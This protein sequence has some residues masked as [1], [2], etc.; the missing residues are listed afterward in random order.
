MV[1]KYHLRIENK[2]VR[3]DLDIKR[4]FTVIRGNSAM[5]KTYL[6]D[7][8]LNKETIVTCKLRVTVLPTQKDDY[9]D[10][11]EKSN[12]LIIID[13]DVDDMDTKEFA[14]LLKDSNNYFIIFSRLKLA[15][16]P[17][18]LEEIY[19]FT[20][21]TKYNNMN[22]PFTLTTLKSMYN[23]IDTSKIIPDLLIT[24]DEKSGYQFF[25][26]ILDID[27]VSAM[28]NSKVK[29]KL[30]EI[31][32]N[33]NYKCIFIIVDGAAFGAF[34]D[35]IFDTIDHYNID[36]FILAPESFEYLL[37]K[38]G[39]VRCNNKLL[40]ETYDYCDKK[41]FLQECPNFDLGKNKLV[42][43]EQFYTAYIQYL[44]RG[45]KDTE[46]AKSILKPYYFRYKNAVLALL[47]DK[48]LMRSK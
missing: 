46:Y 18:S 29:V 1:G 6:R 4:K 44:S 34:V 26:N 19:E 48:Y 36:I 27:C 33:C 22:V 12:R 30:L 11:L 41:H 14:D 17:I 21:I 47:P 20:S 9:V 45:N 5:G 42:S 10:T 32:K 38:A 3:Y 37:L 39:A 23:D 31:L 28:G 13:E 16:L 40:D 2:K 8:V 7:I 25:S 15:F 24:E 35:E 43:W